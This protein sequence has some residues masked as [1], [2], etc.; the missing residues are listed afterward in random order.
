[1]KKYILLSIVGL[2]LMACSKPEKDNSGNEVDQNDD[3]K[4]PVYF[5]SI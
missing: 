4:I 3:S 1:M 2:A 5:V